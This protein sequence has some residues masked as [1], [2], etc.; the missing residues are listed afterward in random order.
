MTK[1][2]GDVQLELCGM[3][4]ASASA[5]CRRLDQGPAP[6]CLALAG[7]AGGL[8]PEL[9]A[10]AILVADAA[11]DERGERIPCTP[12]HLPGATVGALVT[13]A[14]PL[15]TL[16]EKQAALAS[17]ASLACGA[18]AA[19]MEAYPLADWAARHRL[20]FIHARIILDAADEA[21]P[22]LGEALDP[23]GGVRPWPFIQ[24][25]LRRPAL[26]WDLARLGWRIAALNASLA[27]L[28]CALVKAAQELAR[29]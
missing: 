1:I 3:G 11:L 18:L 22:G 8:A 27:G 9:R 4:M 6:G 2:T 16:A 24:A 14:R 23:L 17:L 19:E 15:F 26:A 13:V 29:A 12:I 21:L 20:P 7:W 25:L 5:L 10:G 28:V